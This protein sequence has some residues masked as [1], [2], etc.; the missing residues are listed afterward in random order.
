RPRRRRRK[1]IRSAPRQRRERARNRPC[2]C[3]PLAHPRA[4]RVQKIEPR[5]FPD[6]GWMKIGGGGNVGWI[7]GALCSGNGVDAG[8]AAV[9]V[10]AVFWPL[11]AGVVAMLLAFVLAL[12]LLI[13]AGVAAFGA[14][15]PL[16]PPV[17]VNAFVGM[18]S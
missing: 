14:V 6:Y 9:P 15:V 2:R 5:K 1:T 4:R 13:G 10:V 18:P 12:V 11:A 8:A 7:G 16:P 17:V 3:E